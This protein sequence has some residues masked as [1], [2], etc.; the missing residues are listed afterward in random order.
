MFGRG[1]KRGNK[2]SS[3]SYTA[4]AAITEYHKLAAYKQQTFATHSPGG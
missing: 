2:K 4:N 3:L 1:W